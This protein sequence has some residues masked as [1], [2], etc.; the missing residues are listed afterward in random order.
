MVPDH[1]TSTILLIFLKVI[2]NFIQ[3]Q[4]LWATVMAVL[5]KYTVG[6]LVT[7]LV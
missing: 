1:L 3:L 5:S 2:V 7:V 4:T 6:A